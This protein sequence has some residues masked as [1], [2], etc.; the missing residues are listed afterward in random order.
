MHELSI[1]VGIIEGVLEESERRG[2]LTVEAV[3]V[4][5]GRMS[6]VDK[7]ALLFAYQIARQ[8]TP[9][10]SARLEIE[11]VNLVI[12]CPT[13]DREL[14]TEPSAGAFCPRCG[15]LVSR[16]VQGDELE[17]TALEIAA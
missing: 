12:F 6:G 2:G 17:I 13:C 8:D 9:L 16:V 10:A 7:D 4:R 14:E 3:R 1:A 11:D 5:L 15:A